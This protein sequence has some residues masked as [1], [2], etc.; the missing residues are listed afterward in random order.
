MEMTLRQWDDLVGDEW[1][2]ELL[3]GKPLK[4]YKKMTKEDLANMLEAKSISFRRLKEEFG[5]DM[6]T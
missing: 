6:V 1:M 5:L 2:S 4:M 3:F